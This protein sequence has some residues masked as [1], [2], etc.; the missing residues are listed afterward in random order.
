MDPTDR[1]EYALDASLQEAQFTPKQME[2]MEEEIVSRH[3][4][5]LQRVQQF[6]PA[7]T[8]AQ[9]EVM[10]SDVV[11]WLCSGPFLITIC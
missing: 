5:S 4:I 3:H 2:A 7:F 10:Q 9:V 8:S 6:P 1:R 11:T